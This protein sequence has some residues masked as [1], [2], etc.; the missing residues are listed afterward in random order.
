M[1]AATKKF[2]TFGG[3]FTPAI[4]TILGVIMYMRLPWIVGQGGLFAALGIIVVAHLISVTTGLSVS[5]IATDK[6][7]DAGGSY[8]IIS[9]SLGL[10]LGGTLG[11]ALFLGL[12]FSVSLYL[13]GFAESYLTA[14]DYLVTPD[15]IRLTGTIALVIVTVVTFISTALAIKTQYFIMAAI[16]LSV[17]SIIAGALSGE[18]PIAGPHFTAAA[19]A[20]PVATLFAIFFPAVTGFEAGVSM[21]GDLEDPRRSIPS[22][23]LAA[24]GVGLIVYIALAVLFAYRI[25]SGDLANDPGVLLNV[26]VWPPLVTAGVFGATISSALGSILGAPR[27]LQACSLDGITPRFFGHGAGASN[28]P[29]RAVLVTFAIAWAGILIGELDAIARVVSMF[30]IMTYGFLNLSCA[31]ESWASPDFRPDFRIPKWVSLLGA[32]TCFVTMIQLDLIAMLIATVAM[33][34]GFVWLKRRQLTLDE[35]DTWDGIWASVARASLAKL[36]ERTR[37]A[38]N[39]RPSLVSFAADLDAPAPSALLGTLIA[40]ARGMHADFQLVLSEHP[41]TSPGRAARRIETKDPLDTMRAICRYH[42]SDALAPNTALLDASWLAGKA[43]ATERL[44][45]DLATLGLNVG[46]ASVRAPARLERPRTIALWTRESTADLAFG[47]ALLRELTA[48]TAWRHAA[49]HITVLSEDG[50]QLRALEQRLRGWLTRLRVDGELQVLHSPRA[51]AFGRPVGDTAAHADLHLVG[52]AHAGDGE[53]RLDATRIAGIASRLDNVLFIEAASDFTAPVPRQARVRTRTEG[54]ADGPVPAFPRTVPITLPDDVALRAAL[55]ELE[56]GLTGLLSTFHVDHIATVRGMARPTTA[57]IEALGERTFDRLEQALATE[58][59]DRRRKAIARLRSDVRNRTERLLDRLES[60]LIADQR[61]ALEAGLARLDQD[62]AALAA[63]TESRVT[64]SLNDARIEPGL[65]SVG[66]R[67]LAWRARAA[68]SLA[69][70]PPVV[71][72]RVAERIP[73]LVEPSVRGAVAEVVELIGGRRAGTL[74]GIERLLGRAA[75]A[76]ELASASDDSDHEGREAALAELKTR[77]ADELAAVRQHEDE[78][79]A[80][81]RD[82]LLAGATEGMQ[83]IVAATEQVAGACVVSGASRAQRESAAQSLRARNALVRDAERHSRL[84]EHIRL[85]QSLRAFHHRL[86]AAVSRASQS[87]RQSVRTRVIGELES[88]RAQISAALDGSGDAR[89]KAPSAMSGGLDDDVVIATLRDETARA[90]ADLPDLANSLPRDGSDGVAVGETT[91]IELRRLVELVLE[92]ELTSPLEGSL[93]ALK[94]TVSRAARV[95]HDVASLTAHAGADVDAASG[96]EPD[97]DLR[98]LFVEAIERIDAELEAVTTG[99]QESGEEFRLLEAAVVKRTRVESLT[100]SAEEIE[101][102]V[103][104]KS[105]ERAISWAARA[106]DRVNLVTRE[107]LARLVYERSRGVLLAR[108]LARPHAESGAIERVV[109]L[110]AACEPRPEIEAN[111][112]VHYAQLFSGGHAA[113]RAYRVS[114]D[115]EMAAAD[116]AV[117]RRRAGRGGALIVTGGARSGIT[118]LALSILERHAERDRTVR[119][120]PPEAGSPSPDEL[121]MAIARAVGQRGSLDAMLASLPP[122]TALFFHDIEL[123]WERAPGGLAAIDLLAQLIDRH[124]ARLL[125][126]LSINTHALRLLRRLG[127]LEREALA[128][129][130]AGPFD[131]LALRRAIMARHE[132][133]GLELRLAGLDLRPGEWRLARAFSSLFDLTEGA[134]GAALDGWLAWLIAVDDRSVTIRTTDPPSLKAL[135]ALDPGLVGLLVELVLH[136]RLD[137]ARLARV[138]GLDPAAL[139]AATAALIRSGLAARTRRGSLELSRYIRP[140]IVRW[141]TDREVL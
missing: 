106:L 62:L 46:V 29:R 82:A 135:D 57:E 37:H 99:L 59:P 23:T 98:E 118:S 78:G 28:E 33:V 122:G 3:V 50:A 53:S 60:G 125:F 83:R 132:S 80:A 138:T 27:I 54:I 95:A 8:Y 24:I 90:L 77:F 30:F 96:E 120:N 134:V 131:A 18:A 55:R 81:C 75:W 31:L 87:V 115:A 22:G 65:G 42:G 34:G 123:W 14:N 129:I 91:E 137:D 133:S 56:R 130:V 13:I 128:T 71:R 89:P 113:Y 51:E 72:A 2:G 49:V 121:E 47:V 52:L 39:W 70:R 41:A 86:Q 16:F 35:G 104:Q 38:R 68:A 124:S 109:T 61:A 6:R 1:A 4:L 17:V 63:S 93:R 139:A 26:S 64:I 84:I 117:S 67:L 10:A 73:V 36:N 12:S 79:L 127:R 44:L 11:I 9:R 69:G 76:I 100:G 97:E 32:A 110:V 7:V 20:V 21:S 19:T 85:D 43:D 101:R 119:I 15:A 40:E 94:T 88:L 111:L 45:S 92:T 116:R 48:R 141:L 74:T 5:S 102:F 108:R 105:N 107:G 126:V 140:H 66:P 103:R 136:R 114:R 25:P 112:S 58:R